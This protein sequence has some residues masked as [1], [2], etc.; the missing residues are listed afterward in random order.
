MDI[1][2][3][4]VLM[5]FFVLMLT[6]IVGRRESFSCEHRVLPQFCVMLDGREGERRVVCVL[7]AGSLLRGG[8]NGHE[9]REQQTMT[10]DE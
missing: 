1:V 5:Y 9:D 3:R 8:E 10:N 2:L 7:G 6:R 4:A